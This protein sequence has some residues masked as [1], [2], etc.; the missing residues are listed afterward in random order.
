MKTARQ[1]PQPRTKPA[2]I[3]MEEL[4][5]SAQALFLDKGIV[6]T[7]IDE[8][9][10]KAGV[11]KGTFYHYFSSKSDVVA[12]LRERFSRRFR[13]QTQAA[14]DSVA[15]DDWAGK[16]E[17][18][19]T[20]AVANYIAEYKLHDI[21]FHEQA[22]HGRGNPG[23][24]A[25]LELIERLVASGCRAK[26]WDV[27]DPRLAA[28]VIFHSMHGAVDDAIANGKPNRKK[29]ARDLVETFN[30]VLAARS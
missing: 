9:V 28:V 13:E 1:T 11:S 24:V 2:D 20:T 3:R 6:G 15:D 23:L 18:W 12:A 25:N 14:I 26:A 27:S 4:M 30:R 29:V 7:I 8:I 17:A 10:S 22:D 16:I 5:D 21:I 19:T